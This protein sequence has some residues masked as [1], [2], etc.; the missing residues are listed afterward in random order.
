MVRYL[1]RAAVGAVVAFLGLCALP[2]AGM[3]ACPYSGNTSG[4]DSA[5]Q[6]NALNDI[7][8]KQ[9]TPFTA[10][11]VYSGNVTNTAVAA[12]ASATKMRAYAVFNG[13]STVCYLQFF[14]IAQGSVTVGTTPNKFSIGFP[15]LGGG[16]LPLSFTFA[17]AMTVA[18]TTTRAGGSACTSGLDVNLFQD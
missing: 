11:T 8:G 6:L 3:A 12:N 10:S 16:N 2:S 17:T 4:T 14:D 7:C 18:A 13:N 5:A 9:N 15:A 1:K